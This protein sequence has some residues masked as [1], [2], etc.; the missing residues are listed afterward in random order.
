MLQA[1]EASVPA[2]RPVR[3]TA[4]Y[5]IVL[6]RWD[7]RSRTK[8]VE[9]TRPIAL[10][11]RRKK[12]PTAQQS[13]RVKTLNKARMGLIC[14][15]NFRN[16]SSIC[17]HPVPKA[18]RAKTVAQSKKNHIEQ[19]HHHFPQFPLVLWVSVPR[20]PGLLEMPTRVGSY[21]SE[22]MEQ[23]HPVAAP[24]QLYVFQRMQLIKTKAPRQFQTQTARVLLSSPLPPSHHFECRRHPQILPKRDICKSFSTA[25]TR[26]AT[27]MTRKS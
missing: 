18:R 3:L 27:G 2:D 23:S 24:S 8:H 10:I 6:R 20:I 7:R 21:P 13:R 26:T 14:R 22:R 19:Y 5:P 4:N 25:T 15:L 1:A 11:M 16:V 17:Y 12:V 9:V